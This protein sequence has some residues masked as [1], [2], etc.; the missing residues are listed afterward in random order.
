MVRKTLNLLFIAA[1]LWSYACSTVS[2]APGRAA[3][4]GPCAQEMAYYYCGP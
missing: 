4:F 2:S 1:L 3:A